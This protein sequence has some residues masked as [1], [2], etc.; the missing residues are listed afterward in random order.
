[1]L[2]QPNYLRALPHDLS[3]G[4]VVFLVALPLCLGIA[5][6][7]GAPLLSGLVAG[8]VGGL[9]VAW[10]SG[11]HTSVS[12][13]AAGLTAVVAAQIQSLGSFEAFL[14]AVVLAGA[15]QIGL[16]VMKMGAL[17]V[18]FPSSVIKGLLSAIGIILILKQIPHLFGHDPDWLGDMSFRQVDGANTFTEIFATIFDV[19]PGATVVGLGSLALL[20]VWDRTPLKNSVVPGPLFVVVAGVLMAVGLEQIGGVWQIAGAHLVQVPVTESLSGFAAALPT[21]DFS[22]LTHPAILTASVTIALVASLE[23]L[24]NL[25]AVDKLDPKQRVSPP[26][27]ELLAQGVG[28]MTAGLAGG[29]P[30]TSVIVRSSVNIGS[31]AQTRVSCFVHGILLAGLVVAMPGLL[32]LIPLS[33]LAAV[34]MVTGF[35]LAAPRL[36]R[37][38]WRE[39]RTQFLPYVGTVAA[40]VLTDLLVG[41]LIGMA[42]AV[43]FILQNNLK[44]PL[45]KINER[46][47]GGEVMR[48]ELAPQL[49]FLNR[50]SLTQAFQELPPGSHVVLDARNTVYMDP[51]IMDLIRDFETEIAPAHAIDVSVLGFKEHYDIDD[52]V[53]YVDVT[54]REIQDRASP[55]DVL[56][57]LQAGNERFVTGQTVSRDARRQIDGT[58]TAQYPLAVVLACM[59]SRIATEM[60]FDLGL[61]DIFSVRVA[62]NIA[63]EQALGSIEYGCAI[64]G[65]KLLLVLGH[66]RCGAVTA[67]VD[68]VDRGP[69]ALAPGDLE[70]LPAITGPIAESVRAETETAT[71]RNAHNEEFVRRVSVVNVQRT[72]RELRERST[73]LRTM[74]EDGRVLLAGGLYDV[75]TGEVEFLDSST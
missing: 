20:L 71:D 9:L 38:M 43:F 10:L 46:H 12:G 70:H 59:D 16:G 21:P 52:R 4:V 48:I 54:T 14:V 65:A 6:A 67:T 49:S 44:R 32:N 73:T 60:I 15:I 18:F 34:L 29:L 24:L 64:A 8:I 68:L 50:A 19:H 66:T 26:N 75:T 3:A 37:Q 74:I 25:E 35:K 51:D 45:R 58:S 31:G 55:K 40:I 39:G 42:V 27:R 36:F 61:G 1:M 53:T 41:I 33:C 13:P 11:S 63:S 72:M 62:G 17:A 30:I 47:V 69:A 57:M 28:N 56:Q 7:S 5:L 22:A 23:T 2:A